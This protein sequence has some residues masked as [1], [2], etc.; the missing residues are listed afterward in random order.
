MFHTVG[1]QPKH[2]TLSCPLFIPVSIVKTDAD[3]SSQK[4]PS[5]MHNVLEM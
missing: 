3:I 4:V 2:L 5:F 1:A